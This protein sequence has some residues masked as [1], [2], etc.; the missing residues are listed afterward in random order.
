MATNLQSPIEQRNLHNYLSAKAAFNAGDIPTCIGY[1]ALDH[2]IRSQDL[3]KGREFIE[4]FLSSFREDWPDVQVVTERTVVKDDWLAAWC[5]TSAT[6]AKTIWEI[7][8]THQRITTT[9]WEMH[10]FGPDGMIEESW[11]LIDGLSI[12]KQI[13]FPSA[14]DGR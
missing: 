8:P 12:M 3:G 4:Q 13:G 10:R 11:N 14:A 1:Y 7:P 5:S 2:Q 6:H 9:F